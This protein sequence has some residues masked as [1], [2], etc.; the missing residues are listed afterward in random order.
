LHARLLEALFQHRQSFI[1]RHTGL[2][3]MPELLGKNE[4][5]AMRNF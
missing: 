2:E 5:L 3:Q 1:E 4:Q